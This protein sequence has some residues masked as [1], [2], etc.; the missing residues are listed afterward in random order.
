MEN[1][2]NVD[3]KQSLS[4]AFLDYSA[5][6]LQRR[7]IPDVRDGLKW[8]ARQLLHAQAIAKLTCD[9]PFKKALKSVGQ[10][11]SFSYTHGDS[12]C[13]GTFIRMA[14]PFSYRYVLQEANGNYGTM[15]DP[16]D[17]SASRYVEI[18]GSKIASL[19]LK[20]LEKNTID[21]WEDTYDLEDK[22]PRVLP[23]KGYYNIVNGC[24]S[25]G[26]GMS[27]SIPQFNLREVNEALIK[28]IKNPEI[29][30]EE[31]LCDPDFATGAIL[32]NRSEVRESLKVG[33]GKSCK[34]RSVIEYN[35]DEHSLIVKEIPYSVFTNTICREL[36]ELIE[37]DP[38]CGIK[39]FLDTTGTDVNLH[40]YLT[41]NANPSSVIKKLY[42]KTSLQS[43]Y[44]VNMIMLD[45]GLY[46]RR[47][48]WKEM[49]QAHIDHEKNVYRK[50]FEYDLGKYEARIHIING[51]LIALKNIEE[52]IQ[53][54]KT[55]KTTAEA[56]ARLCSD[57]GLT[58]IQAK[59]IL[60]IKLAR[61]AHLEIEKYEKEFAELQIKI[62]HI[63]EILNNEALFNQQLIDGWQD[64]I[65]RFS[66]ARRTK[67]MDIESDDEDEPIEKK[68]LVVHLTNFNNVYVY[69]DSSLI[70][71]RRGGIGS[72]VKMSDGETI[73]NTIS[74]SNYNNILLF[75]DMGKVYNC[76]FDNVVYNTKVPISTLV[77]LTDGEKITAMVSDGEKD[78][79]R[80]IVFLTK[81]GMI[82][83][84]KLKEYNIKKSKG[85]IAMKLKE[86]D[87]II[88]VF[89]ADDNDIVGIATANGS[90]VSF[91]M[92]EVSATGRATSGVKAITLRSGDCVA[93]S[94][95][96][97]P[98]DTEI[99]SITAEGMVKKTPLD[100]VPIGSR[101]NKGSSIHKLQEN[102]TLVGIASVS[103]KDSYIIVS[104]KTS[105]IKFD[106]SEVRASGRNTSGTKS[107]K[108][109]KDNKVTG[110]FIV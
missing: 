71:Q 13:Y 24:I 12:S 17:H 65:N 39:N 23:T 48:G 26:S 55:S 16:N 92:N 109:T 110:V 73:I 18:R 87:K 64:I 74:D 45:K 47:F 72:K 46:P 103:E 93:K 70:S 104:S 20:D 2:N 21:E 34:L 67:V 14:K 53:T 90:Y 57:F 99:L 59:A 89:M 69:E 77:E 54:I 86:G 80:F 25:I 62:T 94:V 98:E 44:S 43:H 78:S 35:A 68:Q 105:C 4:Q 66:D 32:V 40:I 79:S 106:L 81:N 42:K 15:I 19:L 36:A 31:I 6:N 28:L 61:L 60:D 101:A 8:S 7:A 41:K 1:I 102:D 49:L 63:K 76:N 38:R 37:N 96:I 51:I 29:D 88:D 84:S 95:L 3:A 50:S 27:C 100:E 5:Y 52:V 56:S 10:A 75:S 33:G 30:V 22:F 108:L 58:E 82:K 97:K 91:Q 83:K 107:I 85:V 11:T 9:K